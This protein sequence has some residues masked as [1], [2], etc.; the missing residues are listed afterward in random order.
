MSF[1]AAGDVKNAVNKM[2]NDNK[3]CNPTV[4]T[5]AD[6]KAIFD[7]FLVKKDDNYFS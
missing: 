5:G 2:C 4:S 1:G 6:A 3:N 7:E